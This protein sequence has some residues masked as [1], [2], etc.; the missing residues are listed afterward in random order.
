MAK[1]LKKPDLSGRTLMHFSDGTTLTDKEVWPHQLTDGQTEAL[2]SVERVIRG[3]HLSIKKSPS[4]RNFFIMT[5]L[6]Q[7]LILNPGKHGPPPK[8]TVRALG[9]YLKGS[10]PPIRVTLGMDPRTSN[11][12]LWVEHVKAFRPDGF[13]A[14]LQKRT[15]KLTDMVQKNVGDGMIWG[16]VNKP[17]IRRILST[18]EGIGCLV[19][20]KAGG[21]RVLVKLERN[22]KN[23]QLL[24]TPG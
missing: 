10:D 11:V 8:I 15:R 21:D 18:R 17:P 5:E 20:L 19:G 16:I 7:N 12:T 23:C 3:W 14:P 9:C 22:G 4:V 24:I 1:T 2:T 6:T 13:A